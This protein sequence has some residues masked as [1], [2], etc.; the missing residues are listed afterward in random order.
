MISSL[1]VA[2]AL[3]KNIDNPGFTEIEKGMAV[4]IVMDAATHNSITKD[5]MLHVIRWL[6]NMVFEESR[7]E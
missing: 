7:D 2:F 3:F 1:A 6:W 5:D 4:K